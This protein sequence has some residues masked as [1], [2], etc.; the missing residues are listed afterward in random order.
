MDAPPFAR[1]NL[2]F[3]GRFS[4]LTF[5]SREAGRVDQFV[6]PGIMYASLCENR[7]RPAI[8]IAID[9]LKVV[10]KVYGNALPFVL[11]RALALPFEKNT[12]FTSPLSNQSVANRKEIFARDFATLRDRPFLRRAQL[13]VLVV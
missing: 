12:I 6:C 5:N 2:A 10:K 3:P 8:A 7:Q 1:S 4:G 11:Q 13:G 9:L